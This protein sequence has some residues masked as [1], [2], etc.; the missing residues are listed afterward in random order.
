M[1][2]VRSSSKPE[3]KVVVGSSEPTEQVLHRKS[4]KP[5]RDK[6]RD[7]SSD[8]SVA[9]DTQTDE[10]DDIVSASAMLGFADP[11]LLH[12]IAADLLALAS[13]S[14]GTRKD[15]LEAGVL[16]VRSVAPKNM[17]EGL[18]AIQMAAIHQA[19]IRHAAALSQA[20]TALEIQLA[21]TGLNKLAR[22][23]T[24]QVEVLQRL[25]EGS[26]RTMRIE[27][28]TVS[29]GGQAILGHVT[30]GNLKNES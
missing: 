6:A 22:T 7:A 24:M 14:S 30:Q 20:E 12:K 18:L 1:T 8:Y 19:T 27:R 15:I 10:R 4:A 28:V 11:D 23:F 29:D 3:I 9:N 21:Q 26:T 17:T 13:S 25:R 2:K 5:V 16:V